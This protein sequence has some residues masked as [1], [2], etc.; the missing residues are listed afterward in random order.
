MKLFT[1]VA[2]L[3]TLVFMFTNAN[4][5]FK[6]FGLKGGVQLNGVMPA[7]EFE[8]DNGLSLSSYL[9]RGFLRFELADFL[10]AELGA[11][12][13]NL[14][15][16]DFNYATMKKG[17]G[18]YS[19]SII[20]I[21]LRLLLTPFNMESLNPYLYAGIGLLRY[22][23]G[24]KP[25]VI[26][27]LAVEA[28]GWTMIIP[29]GIG[30]EIK[31]SDQV[32]LDLSAGVNYSLTEN[33]NYFKIVDYTDGYFNVGAGLTF[34]GE[35]CN[36][37]KDNDGLTRCEEEELG[38]D[39][40]NPDTDGDGLKDGD[41]VHTYKTDPRNPD[42]DGDG[43]KD[44]EEVYTYK[45]NPLKADTDGDGLKD[46]EEVMKYKT[47][48][49]K[50]DTD[51][52]GL[53]DGDEVFKYKTDP[54]NAD[55]DGDGLKD[56]E[57]VMKYKTD[58]LKGDTDGGTI[59]DGV[60]VKRGTN[61]LDP[62]DDLPQT[63]ATIEKQ[64]IYDNVLFDV[65]KADLSKSAK[66]TLDGVYNAFLKL[67]NAKIYLKGHTSSPASE[68]YNMDLSVRRA[69]VVK[70]YLVKKGIDPNVIFTEAF[71]ETKPVSSNDNEDGRSD[72]RRTEIKVVYSEKQ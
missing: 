56:G 8:D 3:L 37:D 46:G 55:T 12:Y 54:L 38:T 67:N 34:T 71:G 21:D 53:N 10:N 1:K 9:I 2:L 29:F 22:N 35:S 43:L 52:D 14:S 41:E 13:G 23:V 60:E 28:D 39:P 4:A 32:L 30:T 44:G 62:K 65:D 27:P 70:D 45:T 57:E 72:N 68:K 7:T 49:L 20:P 59:W 42:T 69:N 15:G 5:Q 31:L 25:S 47:D 64:M 51:G 40:R 50:A 36:S 17:T 33:L 19:T 18:E 6:D 58:P 16:D 24:T 48:P 11:G 26:S 66:A 63:P 61:P